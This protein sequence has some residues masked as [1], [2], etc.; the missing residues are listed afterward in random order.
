M[1]KCRTPSFIL[2]KKLLTSRKDEEALGLRFSYAVKIQCQLV[3]H[4]RKQIQKLREDGEYRALLAARASIPKGGKR[5]VALDQKLGEKRLSFGLSQY[6]FK[7]WVK[8]MQHRYRKHIDSRSAQSIAD[9][10]WKAAEE[11]LFGGGK[12]LHLPK[13]HEVRSIESNDNATGIKYHSGRIRWNGLEMQVSRDRDNAYENEALKRRVK[14]CRI[15]R[16]PMGKR[17]HYYIQ[18]VLEGYPPKK[19]VPGEGRVG[20]DPGTMSVAVASEN[21]CILTSLTGG[22]RSREKEVRRIQRAMDRS[23]RAMNPDRFNEDGTMKKKRGRWKESRFYRILAM[24]KRSLEQRQAACRKD[25]HDTLADRI[26]ALGDEV[27]TETMSYKSLQRRK[28]E[29]TVNSRGRYDRRG[30]FGKSLENGAP[31]MLLSIIE[32]KLRY[33]GKALHKVNTR[34]FRA[35][36]YNHVTDEYVKKRLSRRHNTINGRWVQRDLYSAFLLMNSD[37]FLEHADRD[38][39][40]RTY[41]KFL[42]DHDRCINEV[43]S[44]G[45]QILSSFGIS[46]A[47]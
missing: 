42:E 46:R 26:L 15:V 10:V 25:H 7:Q 11:V 28:K 22:V 6:Q 30:R 9:D 23:R 32:R 47:A 2:E 39:C 8:P 4:A 40:I 24:R 34:T 31:A 17:W 27:Y 44:S 12:K 41:D 20:I 16:R 21:G 43:I 14:Y 33:E 37:A 38:A 45:A 19:H 29:T 3:K 5:R 1:G 36:Q 35:S 13:W 18:L